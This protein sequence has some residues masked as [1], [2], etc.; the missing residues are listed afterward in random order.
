MDNSVL[1]LLKKTDPDKELRKSGKLPPL[2]KMKKGGV[3]S[4][5]QGKVMKFKTTKNY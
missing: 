5:G 3:V 4:K 2:K 1:N